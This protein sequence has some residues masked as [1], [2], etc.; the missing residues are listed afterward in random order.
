MMH[1]VAAVMQKR[2]ARHGTGVQA[3]PQV[4]GNRGVQTR[5]P[6][7]MNH[8]ILS[9]SGRCLFRVEPAPVSGHTNG[10]PRTQKDFL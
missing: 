4:I 5:V 1:P 6:R 10:P 7:T 3:R 8:Q 2:C 9:K